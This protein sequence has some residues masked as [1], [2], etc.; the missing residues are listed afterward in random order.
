MK[1][2]F[3]KYH[4]T[5]NDF[6]IIDNRNKELTQANFPAESVHFLCDRR[7]G[8]GADGL[9][10]LEHHENADFAMRYFNADGNEATLCGNGSR[11]I[12]AF[13]KR[14]KIFEQ[15]TRFMAVDGIH[16]A[17]I[18]DPEQNIIRVKLNDVK[19]IELGDD[20]YYL[21]T[22]S[23]HYVK[24][25]ENLDQVD[26]V[27]AGRAIRNNERFRKK[28]TNVNFVQMENKYLKVRTYERGVEDETLSCGTGVTACAISAYFQN[29]NKPKNLQIKTK[30]GNLS[31]SFDTDDS[32]II[33][34]IWLQASASYVFN[35]NIDL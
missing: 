28:G 6:V 30:G 13:A 4:G 31:V 1:L 16:L 9:M 21:D 24:Y 26:V 14:L 20:F 27:Q 15:K 7:F 17:E 33:K 32:K 29:A 34:N 8:V 3:Y 19:D 5:G 25:V 35:G 18:V 22:G 11:C 23:P 10:L 12:V 2:N